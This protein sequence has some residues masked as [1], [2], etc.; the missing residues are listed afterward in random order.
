MLRHGENVLTIEEVIDNIPEGLSSADSA[1]MFKAI[2]ASWIK[3]V[4]LSDFARQ[5]LIDINAIDKKVNEYRNT[6]IVQEYLTRMRD[7]QSPRI[8]PAKIKDYYDS[9]RKELKL[10]VPLVKGVFL[11]INSGAA[12]KGDIKSLLTSEDPD[13]IDRLEQEW[14][15]KALQYDYFRD[16]WIDWEVVAEMIPH[17][18]GDPEKFLSENNYFETDDGECVYYLHISDWLPAGEEQPFEF[19]QSWIAE[20]L[21][22]G[23]LADYE[24]NLVNSLVAKSLKDKKLEAIGYDPVQQKLLTGQNPD[25]K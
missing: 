3:D 19:A 10:E 2:V 22:Q 12:V 18:F 16:K 8:D 1:A 25:E 14:L 7:S 17:R 9:H 24:D 6:L 23:A 15:D 21:T 13:K 5:R 11:K 20:L 4:V